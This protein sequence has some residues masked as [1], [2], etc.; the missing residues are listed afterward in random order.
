M[1]NVN[2]TRQDAYRVECNKETLAKR[3]VEEGVCV[4][5]INKPQPRPRKTHT[6]AQN[7][8]ELKSTAPSNFPETGLNTII[9]LVSFSPLWIALMINDFYVRFCESL[10]VE[11][12][13]Y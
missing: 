1:G 12:N 10:S 11:C 5:F 3:S 13:I 8:E 7:T 2:Q 4:G 9:R 6:T